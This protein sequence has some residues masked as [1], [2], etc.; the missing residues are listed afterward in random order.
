MAD[1]SAPAPF[2]L[3][4]L[5]HARRLC[6]WM[7][8]QFEDAAHGTVVE[9]GA[10]IGTFSERILRTGVDRLVLVEPDPACARV[11]RARFGEN[12]R[13]LL[14][15]ESVPGSTRLANLELEADF[16]LCQNVLEHIEDDDGAVA[17]MA[18]ALRPGGRLGLLW[19]NDA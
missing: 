11:L 8:S 12:P 4:R 19:R 6:D 3:E 18:R 15:E 10:G 13:V 16:V 14:M 9:I 1:S 17:A 7:F 5:A 2:D